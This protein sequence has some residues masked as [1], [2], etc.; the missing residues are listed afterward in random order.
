MTDNPSNHQVMVIYHQFFLAP[1]GHATLPDPAAPGRLLN[2]DPEGRAAIVRCGC[3]MGPVNV[4]INVGTD[5][6]PDLAVAAAEWE[7]AEEMSLQIDGDLYLV[8]LVPEGPVIKVY[9]P[10]AP[11]PHVVQA[12][13]R[14]RAN[15]YDSVVEDPTEDYLITI[16]PTAAPRPRR[17]VGDD[18]I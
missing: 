2:A 11:G 6:F 16:A 1:Y 13:A 18:T 8:P 5:D 10:P 4:S 15:H 12:F 17:Q 14:G 9:S 3:A 7:I